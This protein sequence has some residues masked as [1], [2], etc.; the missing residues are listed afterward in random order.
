M[1]SADSFANTKMHWK[2]LR[3]LARRLI[4]ITVEYEYS[5]IPTFKFE[6]E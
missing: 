5:A 2:R 1:Q 3:A 6:I 4:A